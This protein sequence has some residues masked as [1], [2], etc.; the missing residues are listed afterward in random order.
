MAPLRRKQRLDEWEERFAK[1]RLEAGLLSA[2]DPCR[3]RSVFS[4]N[5]RTTC[6]VVPAMALLLVG[7]V[8]AEESTTEFETTI[9]PLLNE[10]CLKCH[11]TEK[12]K[13]DLDLERFTTFEEVKRHAKVWQSVEEQLGLGEM[14]PK[15]KPQPS[16]QDKARLASW[17]HGV[18]GKLALERAGDPGPVVLRRLSNAE[19]TWTVRDLTGIAS[20][21]PAREFPVDGAAG[22]GFSNVGAALVMSPA[23]LTKYLDAAKDIAAHAVLLPDGIRFS[24]KTT[25]RDWTDEMLARIRNFYARYSDSGG[26]QKVNLQGVV[27]DTNGGGRLPVEEYLAATLAERDALTN[28]AKTIE[29]VAREH[30][31]NAKYLGLLWNTL[32]SE[33]PSLLLDELRAAWR[34]A[35]PAEA[36]KLAANI[37]V[38]QKA[39]WKFSSVGQIG[40]T[41]GPKAWMEPVDPVTD[42]Q[43]IRLKMP[44]ASEGNEVVISLQA[45][46]AGDGSDHDAVVWEQPRLVAPGRPDLLLRDLRPI[47]QGFEQRRARIFS[48]AA[49][50]LAAATEASANGGSANVADLAERHGVD[51]DVLAAW[52]GYLG[53]GSSG[54]VTIDSLL[55]R[56][57]PRS[58][59]FDFIKGWGGD[60][61]LSVLAN[62]SDQHVRIPGNMKPHGIAVHP[63]PARAVAVG[64][65]S[66]IAAAMKISAHIQHAHPECGNGV[67]WSLELRR[68]Q[69]RQRLAGGVAQGGN[70]GQAGP[71]ENVAIQAG[72]LISIVIGPRD[73]NHSCDLTAIDLTISGGGQTWDLAREISPNIL[74]GNPHADAEGRAG[75]WTFYSEPTTGEDI[76][77]IPQGS[78]L[79]R[80]QSAATADEQ[81]RLAQ[82]VQQLLESGGAAA[83]K[84]SP[85]A[86]LYRQLA[87]L[88]G[89]LFND[90]FKATPSSDIVEG[91]WGL[92]A[93]RFGKM[94]NG[95]AIDPAS[96]GAQAP[97]VIEIHLPADLVEGCEFVTTGVLHEQAGADGSVQLRAVI[98][99]AAAL[100]TMATDVPIIARNGSP[101]RARIESAFAAFRELFPAALCYTKIV[102]VDEVITLILF[103]REDDALCRLM[104]GDAEKVE[105]D[106]MWDD[107]RF[108][109]Q[110]ALTMVSVFDQLWQY[111]TQDAD[112]KVFEPLR[113]PIRDGAAAFKERLTAAEP[114]QLESVLDFA[115]LAWRRPITDADRQELQGLY[116]RLRDE[117][118]P[119]EAALRLTLARVLVAPEFLYKMEE[120]A[121]S[122]TQAP[123]NDWEL[124]ARLSYFLW[125]STPDAELREAAAGEPPART[126]PSS[127]ANAPAAGGLS[128]RAP[129]Q[130]VCRPLAAHLRLRSFRRKER[131][132]VPH[133]CQRSGGDE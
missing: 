18:L 65:R 100:T 103:H 64:W 7:R 20:L 17:V 24:E 128:R 15:E 59:E 47:A 95:T 126:G 93:D 57:I 86:A 25:R 11:S 48:S 132:S 114:R 27:F 104:L 79:A 1:N 76:G 19:Y 106:G 55:E 89:P 78:V 37:A 53:I 96:L 80:W 52:L 71:I 6:I 9:R 22:E 35:G 120:P 85:D 16:P 81:Q 131:T 70:E 10:F 116:R 13:G 115:A 119:H 36:E 30:S 63:L 68:G 46:T 123:V 87:S 67:T 54:E 108:I 74:A 34:A 66:P 130:R 43:E 75:V 23:T 97:D 3:D 33:E 62:S 39:L 56:Q 94:P 42:R 2:T 133:L 110:D 112:P 45:G 29:T 99:P 41:G 49:K 125:S 32:Q 72:D 127:R 4:M 101:T 31:L 5:F 117:E 69:T 14:P 73:G 90:A 8:R 26:A 58:T 88:R 84:D 102:P 51:T 121:D 92:A 28:G 107:L 91:K 50:C 60:D 83:A 21:D 44:A 109:S 118:L 124:A 113:Q 77:S 98:G 61:A 111:A 38:F 105:L 129:G 82:A 40:K 122:A 12:Q